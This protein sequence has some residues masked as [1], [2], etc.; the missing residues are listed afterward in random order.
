MKSS[1]ET[2]SEKK[3]IAIEGGGRK[4]IDIQHFLYNILLLYIY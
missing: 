1:L 2:L 4:K 3:E